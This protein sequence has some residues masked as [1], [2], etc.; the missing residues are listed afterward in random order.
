MQRQPLPSA[1]IPMETKT[2][3]GGAEMD[4]G[5]AETDAGWTP[6]PLCLPGVLPEAEPSAIGYREA[7]W[8]LPYSS[9][10]H[11]GQTLI[12]TVPPEGQDG[13]MHTVQWAVQ[14]PGNWN[15]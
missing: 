5:G 3:R 2:D 12:A 7:I 14:L 9:S 13:D 11:S 4:Q 1:L 8:N 10:H 15:K 6:A